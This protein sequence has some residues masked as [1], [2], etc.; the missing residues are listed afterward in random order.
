MENHSIAKRVYAGECVG[1]RS[2][3]RQ[4]KRWIDTVKDCLKKIVQ[5][6][7]DWREFVK[8]D[9]WGVARVMNPKT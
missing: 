6:R 9:V 5:D 3:D 7:G 4:K 2:V 8:G 1:S